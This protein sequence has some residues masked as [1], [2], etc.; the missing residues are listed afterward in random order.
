M[1]QSVVLLG[2]E[3]TRFMAKLMTRLLSTMSKFFFLRASVFLAD[4]KEELGKKM[5]D[6][7]TKMHMEK[8]Q[9]QLKKDQ[10]QEGVGK[11]G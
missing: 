2:K 8:F 9:D 3:W 4:M 10:A 7:L 5:D 1:L 11:M 6:P